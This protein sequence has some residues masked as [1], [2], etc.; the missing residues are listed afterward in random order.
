MKDFSD[1]SGFKID[2][3]VIN[4]RTVQRSNEESE[5]TVAEAAKDDP[6]PFKFMS[7]RCKLLSENEVIIDNFLHDSDNINTVYSI[8]FCGLK[9]SIMSLSL[10]INGLYIGNEIYHFQLE[11]SLQRLPMYLQTVFQLL[12]FRDEAIKINNVYNDVK[13]ISASK[14]TSVKGHK[15]NK[16][17]QTASTNLSM[18]SWTR[19]NWVPPRKKESPLPPIPSKLVSR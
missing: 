19:G 10:S 4:D 9:M 3:R 13:S 1:E 8:Q 7:D 18:L 2:L 14:K 5:V 17:S 12:C 6:G 11:N 15:Y 16:N